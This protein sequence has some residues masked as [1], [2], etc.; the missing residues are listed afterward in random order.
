MQ[1]AVNELTPSRIREEAEKYARREV[2]SQMAQFRDLGIMANWSP[3]TTYRT[4][5]ECSG[6]GLLL[7]V[8]V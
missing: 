2:A 4:L 6:I 8:F 3:E 7:S 5:G 1:A